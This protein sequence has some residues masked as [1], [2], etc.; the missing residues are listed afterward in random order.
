MKRY[1]A[2][3]NIFTLEVAID[4]DYWR[5]LWKEVKG[6]PTADRIPAQKIIGA[7]V[8]MN[9]LMWTIRY[10]TFHHL[11]EEELI[12]YTLPFGLNV[13]D[14]DIRAIAGGADYVQVAGKIYPGLSRT[15][16]FSESPENRLM[17]LEHAL[18]L[19]MIEQCHA[20]FV[21]DS[22]NVGTLLAFLILCEME[23]Q[24]LILF[25]EAKA[26]QISPREFQRF[27]LLNRPETNNQA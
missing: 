10:Q 22:F 3:Q 18:Q 19:Q 12:N 14:E 1:T 6:L 7:L 9:N 8:D 17:E 5:R 25:I 21:G 13:H 27:Q 26:Q 15:A 16:L 2:E 23:I 4:L 20:A 24:D 11:T